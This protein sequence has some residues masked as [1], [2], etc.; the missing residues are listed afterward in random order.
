[1]AISWPMLI[2]EAVHVVLVVCCMLLF[3]DDHCASGSV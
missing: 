2:N 3:A 1:V